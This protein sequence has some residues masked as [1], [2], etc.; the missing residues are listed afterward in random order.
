MEIPFVFH[1]LGSTPIVG[2]RE[3]R[4]LLADTMSDTWIAFARSGDPNHAGLPA[5]DPY[6]VDQRATML[7]DVPPRLESDPRAEER[8]AWGDLR[9]SLPW[10]GAAFVGSQAAR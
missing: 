3:D 4:T 8:L 2:T 10:E 1:N 5:W 9:P 7:F 6:D